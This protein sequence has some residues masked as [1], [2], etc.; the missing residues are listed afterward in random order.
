MAIKY[1]DISPTTGPGAQRT[2]KQ[3]TGTITAISK[4]AS[5]VVTVANDFAINDVVAFSGVAGMTEI[6]G[7]TG[8][9]SAASATSITVNI[10]STG[11][12]TYTSG[13]VATKQM[14]VTGHVRLLF[15]D[16]KSMPE[17]VDAIQVAK[18]AFGEFASA[19]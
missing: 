10:A 13:G 14:T 17:I 3:L 7:L 9:I 11:F 19:N 2:P 1:L 18:E 4:A 8:T 6:N 15:N 12:T 16:A 5:A